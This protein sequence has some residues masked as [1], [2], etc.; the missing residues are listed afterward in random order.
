MVRVA[1]LKDGQVDICTQTLLKENV[2]YFNSMIECLSFFV[3]TLILGIFQ[4]CQGA[5]V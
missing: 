3:R 1:K 2:P 4:R 5:Y